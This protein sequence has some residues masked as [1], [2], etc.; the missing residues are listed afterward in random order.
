MDE[1]IY[2]RDDGLSRVWQ[3]SIMPLLEDLFYGQGDLDQHYGLPSLRKAIARPPPSSDSVQLDEL[4][5]AVELPLTSK[6]GRSLAGSG[7]VNAMPS[8]YGAGVWQVSAAGK[9]GAARIGDMEIQIRPKVPIAQLLF[10]VGYSRHAA[11][12]Q[13]ET[14]PVA[15]AADLIPAVAQAL[16]RQTERAIHQGLLPGYITVEES[17][18]VLRGRLRESEQLHRQHGLPLPLEIRHDEFTIDIPENQ[19][20]RTACE[21]ML[22]VPR[23]DAESQRMLRRLLRDFADVTPLSRGDPVPRWQATRINVRY[24]HAL[25]I[26]DLVLRATSVEHGPGDV[27]VNGFLLDMPKLFEDFVTVAMREALVAGYG[28]R[29]SGQDRNYFDDAAQVVLRPDIVWK[30][31]VRRSPSSTPSTRPKSQPGTRTR[32]CTRYSPTARSSTCAPDTSSTPKATKT[33]PGTSCVAPASRL[34]AMPS[35]S[36]RRLTAAGPDERPRHRI[37]ATRVEVC[38]EGIFHQIKLAVTAQLSLP[39]QALPGPNDNQRP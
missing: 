38:G 16:W 23:V 32:T 34:S 19:I 2:R 15:E 3:Y 8:P 5:P 36:T 4:G 13:P 28:G 14:V 39:W 37:A 6:Q 20:L 7:V 29:V 9:I 24:H 30:I 25:R 26:A 27:A 17:S 12:W 35:T 21:R 10:L 31:A 18:Q 11:A 33:P 1:R 22:T